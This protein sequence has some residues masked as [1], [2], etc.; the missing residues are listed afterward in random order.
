MNGEDAFVPLAR[1]LRPNVEPAAE[2][3]AAPEPDACEEPLAPQERDELD[4]ALAAVRRF[5]AALDDALDAA[6]DALVERIAREVVGRELLLAP[7]DLGAIVAE[8]RACYALHEPLVIRVHPDDAACVSANDLGA[9][10]ADPRVQRGDAL[11]EVRSG[12][13]DA[14]LAARLERL[15]AARSPS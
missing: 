2:T 6:L 5:R 13:I 3:P 11:I 9:F 15:L 10:V 4:D 8:A 12:T 1:R 7:A 14:T